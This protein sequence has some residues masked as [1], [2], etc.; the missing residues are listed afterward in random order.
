MTDGQFVILAVH[1]DNSINLFIA[2]RIMT[3]E[4]KKFC[5]RETK[6]EDFCIFYYYQVFID[7]F[8]PIF[9]PPSSRLSKNRDNRVARDTQPSPR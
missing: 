2:P 3:E 1:P 4:R 5:F 6:K 8:A 7:P 9:S